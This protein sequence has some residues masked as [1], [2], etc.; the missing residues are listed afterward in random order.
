VRAAVWDANGGILSTAS[1]ALDVA[2][3][4]GTHANVMV[5]GVIEPLAALF[6]TD[7]TVKWRLGDAS[8]G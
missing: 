2:A 8:L 4:H 6:S 3:E 1:L 5:A 7:E